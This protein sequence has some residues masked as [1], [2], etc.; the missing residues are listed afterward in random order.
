MG[1]IRELMTDDGFSRQKIA[2]YK[3]SCPQRFHH[4][5][6]C[7]HSGEMLDLTLLSP[8][9]KENT[10]TT[11]KLYLNTRRPS[12]FLMNFSLP[13]QRKRTYNATRS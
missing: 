6:E 9:S 1:G 4:Q 7:G 13:F 2:W 12:R 3:R 5:S 8:D 10:Q 11:K